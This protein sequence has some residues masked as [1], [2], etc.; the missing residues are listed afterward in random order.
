MIYAVLIKSENDDI[1]VLINILH[2]YYRHVR[3]NEQAQE[4]K[5]ISLYRV[6]FY[7]VPFY[8]EM[9]FLQRL[10]R[11][12]LEGFSRISRAGKKCM[13]PNKCQ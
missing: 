13:K 7:Q 3:L 11:R 8:S 6:Y 12:C 5:F 9:E 10:K 4:Q 2:L 1:M